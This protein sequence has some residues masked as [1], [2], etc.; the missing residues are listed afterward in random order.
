MRLPPD[1]LKKLESIQ[2][3]RKISRTEAACLL[4]KVAHTILSKLDQDETISIVRSDGTTE[5]ILFILVYYRVPYFL[6]HVEIK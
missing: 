3:K 6:T 1:V 2:K 5:K 4:I